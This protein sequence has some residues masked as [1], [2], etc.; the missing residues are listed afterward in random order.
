MFVSRN[1][2]P[3]PSLAHVTFEPPRP[4]VVAL[5]EKVD[6]EMVSFS[7]R[8]LGRFAEAP[9]ISDYSHC[10]NATSHRL[11]W[12]K[13]TMTICWGL[14]RRKSVFQRD[15]NRF[16]SYSPKVTTTFSPRSLTALFRV[17]KSLK[18]RTE[19]R[20]APSVKCSSEFVSSLRQC[21][22][23][24][25]YSCFPG[26]IPQNE[27][28]FCFDTKAEGP[29]DMNCMCSACVARTVIHNM[30]FHV[31]PGT[32]VLL[33]WR[34]CLVSQRGK[35]MKTEHTWSR[36]LGGFTSWTHGFYM[37]LSF[38]QC[39]SFFPVRP[40]VSA[41]PFSTFLRWLR[42]WIAGSWGFCQIYL[43]EQTGQ[44]SLELFTLPLSPLCSSLLIS[45]HYL[46]SHRHTLNL[47]RS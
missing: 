43:V 25:G 36:H 16:F 14:L 23:P 30:L 41:G 11:H 1:S 45:S 46:L 4:G 22:E 47:R 37:V 2:D 35:Q 3:L 33:R 29:R 44:E 5:S 12:Q 42:L 34:A 40:C 15:W 10:P 21:L 31:V 27:G 32:R 9:S 39:F 38:L 8:N 6:S 13:P 24:P 19:R 18:Q 20:E 28:P 26:C 17:L 7:R